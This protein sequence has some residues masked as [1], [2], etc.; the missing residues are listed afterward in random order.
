[1][2]SGPAVIR[3]FDKCW[4]LLHVLQVFVLACLCY[5]CMDFV[6]PDQAILPHLRVCLL[7]MQIRVPH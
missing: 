7:L 3:C 1:M 4:K 5:Q 6:V 2:V